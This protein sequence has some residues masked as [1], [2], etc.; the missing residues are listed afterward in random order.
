[1]TAT[2]TLI[3]GRSIDYAADGLL[4]EHMRGAMQRYIENRIPPGSFL[5]AVLSNDLMD[6]L[7]RADS[8]N[9][10]RLR[11]IAVWLYNFSPSGCFGSVEKVRAWLQGR[12]AA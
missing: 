3:D 8:V 2:L 9:R 6:A 7:G 11:D 5:M 4:P 1:M 12:D 10:V